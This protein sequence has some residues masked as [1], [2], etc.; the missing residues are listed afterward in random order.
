MNI[1]ELE[2]LK[3]ELIKIYNDELNK[4]DISS[5]NSNE[6]QIVTDELSDIEKEIHK[7]ESLI[8][9]SKINNEALKIA[10]LENLY[11]M[12]TNNIKEEDFNKLSEEESYELFDEYFP[13]N[14][15]Y[16]YNIKEKEEILLDAICSNKLINAIE[17]IK[18]KEMNNHD[19]NW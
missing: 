10:R 2:K 7:V 11:L 18:K 5:L 13:D 17:N 19:L 4:K 16:K 6:K 1:E 8:E 3:E 12:N 9:I 15:P 14:W